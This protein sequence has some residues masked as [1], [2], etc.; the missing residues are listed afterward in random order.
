LIRKPKNREFL[1]GDLVLKWEARRE[2]DGKHGKFD[3][4]WLVPYNIIVVV[5]EGINSFFL[6]RIIG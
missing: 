2:D 6:Q 4:I 3:P 5:V 1:P